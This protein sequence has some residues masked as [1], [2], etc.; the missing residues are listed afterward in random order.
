MSSKKRPTLRVNFKA[1]TGCRACTIA[2]ALSH[3]L[4]VEMYR[5]R[6]RVQKRMPELKVPVFKP[7]FCRMCR[8]AK[9]VSACPTGALSQNGPD[10]LVVLDAGLCDGCGEC[11]EVCPF[12]AIWMDEEG[13]IAIK[14]DL[15]GGEPVCVRYC[16]PQALI[17]S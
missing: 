4:Q 15:C 1:C 6:I 7:V 5:A 9:C 13:G 11:Q 17:F 3:E 2:C 16:A 8:N 12:E 14:C 10:G